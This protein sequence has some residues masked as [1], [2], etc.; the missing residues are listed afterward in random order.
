MQGTREKERTHFASKG[1]QV[2]ELDKFCLVL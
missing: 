2:L 1:L